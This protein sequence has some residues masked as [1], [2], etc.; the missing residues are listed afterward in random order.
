[1]KSKI[2]TSGLF[3]IFALILAAGLVSAA[4]LSY[5]PS[6]VTGNNQNLGRKWDTPLSQM[7]QSNIAFLCPICLILASKRP[8]WDTLMRHPKN[9]RNLPLN[10]GSQLGH[11]ASVHAVSWPSETRH[12]EPIFTTALG[13]LRGVQ[14][15][16]L[17]RIPNFVRGREPSKNR[18]SGDFLV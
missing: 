2:L 3:V 10:R 17:S 6:P 12:F 9:A 8:D 1:M 11:T 15:P 16:Y 13:R 14:D 18:H 5:T 4:G 7:G